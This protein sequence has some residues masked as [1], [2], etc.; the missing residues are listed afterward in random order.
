MQFVAL[1]IALILFVVLHQM[2]KRGISFGIRVIGAA[3]AGLIIGYI[4]AGSTEYVAIFGSVYIRLLYTMVI[5][6][7]LT[8]I[9]RT[10]VNT[11]S[12]SQLRSIGLKSVGILSLHNVLASTLGVI[13]AVA[14]SIGK[15]ANMEAPTD[16][17]IREVPT[18]A[19][20]ITNFFPRNIVKDA[21]DSNIVPIIVFAI[22][23]G[24]AILTLIENGKENETKPFTDF[25]NSAAEVMYKLTSMITGLTPYAVLSLMAAAIGNIDANA[26]KPLI[27]ILVLN[28]VA[29]FI[30]SFITTG[31]LV[32]A[33]AKVNPVKY[34]KKAWPVQVIAF[35]TQS[36]MGSLP[37]NIENLT[38]EQGVSED[39]ASFVAPLG[40]TMGMPGC[41][42]FWPVMNA[43]LTVNMLGMTYTGFDYVRLILVAL[44]V[45]LGTVGVPGTATISTTALFAA[46]G[47]P[48]EMV[49]LLAPISSLADMGRTATNVTAANSS[50]LIVAASE[51][52][53]NRYIFNR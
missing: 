15:G 41:A 38:S 30:H 8:T 2:K 10:M 25:I 34:F 35:T 3:V 45:S 11:G 43:I 32:S 26:V 24:I 16:T 22:L 23:V 17:E 36:S 49:V 4:F 47:L 44:L 42:G 33:F 9:I 5:P 13:L 1:L 39:I 20:T 50:A 48:L 19:E 52:K 12:L 51:N 29:S 7:L 27:L 40:A 31:A 46:M 37:A 14:F 53:L 18:V 28:Y 6:L 21:A